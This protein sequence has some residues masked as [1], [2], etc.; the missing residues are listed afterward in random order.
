MDLKLCA[1]LYFIYLI[2]WSRWFVFRAWGRVGT[3]IGGNKLETFHNKSAALSHFES[4]YLDKT[5]NNWEDRKFASKVPGKFYPL[6]MDY[7]ED[8]EKSKNVKSIDKNMVSKSSLA[9]SIQSLIRL[10]FDVDAMKAQMKEFE[11]R[12][13]LKFCLKIN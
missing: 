1:R 13:P 3:T 6:E 8:D 2:L 11:V 12:T 7:G 9:H 10:I 5:G 4:L